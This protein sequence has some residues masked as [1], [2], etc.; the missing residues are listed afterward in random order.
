MKPL[1]MTKTL[2]DAQ[3]SLRR[4]PLV[5]VCAA[6]AAITAIYLVD[7]NQAD[8]SASRILM[9]A[10]LGIPFLLTLALTLEKKPLQPWQGWLIRFMGLLAIAL[11]F[12]TLPKALPVSH[13]IRFVILLAGGHLLIAVAPFLIK[14]SNQALW[15][16]NIHLLLRL[17]SSVIFTLVMYVGLSLAL[18]AM[19]QLLGV[20]LPDDIYLKLFFVL[21]FIFNTWYFL[22]G[23]PENPYSQADDDSFPRP[24]RILAQH[25]LSTLVVVYLAIMMAYLGKIIIT[26][27]WPSGWVGWLVSGVA[28]TGLLSVVLLSPLQGRP[29]NPWIG[30]YFRIFHI[31]MIPS[32]VMLVLAVSKRINQY[33]LTEPRYLLL[34]LSGWVMMILVVG[35][36]SRR[37]NL[38]FIPLSLG[39]LALVISIGPWG[40]ISLSRHS[41]MNRVQKKLEAASLFSHGQLI[42]VQADSTSA[43]RTE[44]INSFEYLISQFGL[45]ELNSW[46]TPS[47]QDS[48]NLMTS[49]GKPKYRSHWGQASLIIDELNVTDQQPPKRIFARH[50]LVGDGRFNAISVNGYEYSLNLETS[51]GNMVDFKWGDALGEVGLSDSGSLLVIQ[52]DGLLLAQLHLVDMLMDLSYGGDRENQDSMATPEEMTFDYANEALKVRLIIHSVEFQHDSLLPLVENLKGL[53]LLGDTANLVPGQQ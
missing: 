34:I 25:I 17:I 43:D 35:L 50:N 52:R 4:F 27:V 16:F 38:R 6:V 53:L 30:I 10:I 26:S 21:G 23:I 33:G 31:L 49:N 11:Y 39:I 32:V 19:D 46:L 37:I 44:L 41:Q 9:T 14:K 18:A 8:D 1:S 5:L 22:G 15:Q 3:L 48:L 47:M 2:V 20:P 45:S 12:F 24:L 51:K 28:V 29:D 7:N 36:W 42:P 40:A 13:F